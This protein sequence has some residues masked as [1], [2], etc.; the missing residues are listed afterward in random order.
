MIKVT[1]QSSK[2][3]YPCCMIYFTSVSGV[4]MFLYYGTKH[5]GRHSIKVNKDNTHLL[6]NI[7][8]CHNV[9]ISLYFLM[10]HLF[11][12]YQWL[13]PWIK[14]NAMCTSDTLALQLKFLVLFKLV[15]SDVATQII[16]HLMKVNWQFMCQFVNLQYVMPCIRE[17]LT[18]SMDG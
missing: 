14:T 9:N 5:N 12:E 18:S 8:Y 2:G 13:W 16:W 3:L 4:F 11:S 7:G 15:L 10:W 6:I 17:F 1:W